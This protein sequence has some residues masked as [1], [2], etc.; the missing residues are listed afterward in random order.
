MSSKKKKSKKKKQCFVIAPIGEEESEERKW[1]D[2]VL[3]LVI[4]PAAEKF[5]YKVFRADHI[6]QAGTITTQIIQLCAEADLVVTN[7][8]DLNANVF[9]EL[10][11]RHAVGKPVI[12]LIE[13]GQNIP[14]D[15]MPVRTLTFD[16]TTPSSFLDCQE[17]MK[18]FIKRME[19]GATEPDNPITT[20]IGALQLSESENPLE[21]VATRMMSMLEELL[22][23]AKSRR[24]L[25]RPSVQPTSI[26][27]P[28]EWLDKMVLDQGRIR[29]IGEMQPRMLCNLCGSMEGTRYYTKIGVEIGNLDSG[30]FLCERC[31]AKK[32]EDGEIY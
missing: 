28:G 26:I 1:S 32:R 21:K 4:K 5:G 10:A 25:E 16:R 7:L 9:Y 15:V 23:V 22:S 6:Q 8:S 27:S 31:A 11:I 18:A 20:A 12:Q 19:E 13:R 17:Q 24:E 3:E 14:F 2:E 30:L 29:Q